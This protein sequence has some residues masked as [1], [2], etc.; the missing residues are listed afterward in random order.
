MEKTGEVTV[1]GLDVRVGGG[2]VKEL[3]EKLVGEQRA[4]RVVELVV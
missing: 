2:L 3:I 4:T 1:V